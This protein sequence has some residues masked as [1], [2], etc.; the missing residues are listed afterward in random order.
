MALLSS[1][2]T[3]GLTSAQ[4]TT[5]PKLLSRLLRE[6]GMGQAGTATAAG[7]TTTLVDATNLQSTQFNSRQWIGGWI[8][9]TSGT[10]DGQIVSITTYAPS[11]GTLTFSPTQAAAPGSSATY[12]LFATPVPPR[13]I[14]DALDT[15][16]TEEAWTP[17]QTLLSEAPDYDMEQ[18]GTTAWSA[19]SNSTI[20]K[21]SW[22]TANHEGVLGNQALG[23][24][25]TAANGYATPASNFRVSP[26]NTY[27][28][29]AFFSPADASVAN[30]GTLT[31]YDV[32]NSAVIQTITTNSKTPVFIGDE[33]IAPAG[34]R[35]VQVRMGSAQN[36]VTGWWDELCIFDRDSEDIA[37]PWWVRGVDNIK[38]IFDFHP[39]EV[40]EE[41]KVYAPAFVGEERPLFNFNF[42]ATGSG[43]MRASTSFARIVR[44]MWMIGTRN[45]VAWASNAEAKRINENWAV[46][47]LATV[48]YDMILSRSGDVDNGPLIERKNTW[49]GELTRQQAKVAYKQARQRPAPTRW[50]TYR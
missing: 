36:A 37:L 29:G 19:A 17:C 38:G 30:T 21:V 45:Q 48:L 9:F 26:G 41:S 8:Y 7:S 1:D 25:T 16:M 46:A 12:L 32:S 14:L 28:T 35:L 20:A 18:S 39:K 33:W 6:T 5:R 47:A 40:P 2:F 4:S 13:M 3:G 10:L 50:T 11:T 23:V 27:Y 42:T 43:Q 31:V 15:I 34:C 22:S 49:N 24:T 44:P